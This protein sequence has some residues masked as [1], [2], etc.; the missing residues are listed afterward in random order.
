MTDLG[1]KAC[2]FQPL[3]DRSAHRR[4]YVAALDVMAIASLVRVW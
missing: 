4:L 3:P 1:I 2:L